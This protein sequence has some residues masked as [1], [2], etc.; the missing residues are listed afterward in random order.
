MK[1]Y[2]LIDS[3][4]GQKLEAFGEILLIRPCQAAVWKPQ[5]SREWERADALF[6]REGKGGWQMKRKLPSSW[7][8][9]I[10]GIILKAAPTDFGHL[11]IFPEHQ[12]IWRLMKERMRKEFSF[13]N[14]FAYSGAASLIAAKEGAKVCHVDASKPMVAWARENAELNRLDKAPIR[15]IIDDAVKF[16]K[17]EQ[18]RGVRYDGILLDPPS[19]GRGPKGEVFKIEEEVEALLQACFDVLSEKPS[20]MIFSSHTPGFTPTVLMNLLRQKREK[21]KI[22]SGELLIES[23]AGFSLPSGNY[24]IWSAHD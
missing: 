11:G 4:N 12:T 21:G 1:S 18:K 20:F 17:R 5:L 14:L 22:T 13:L 10:E 16:L 19:F 2:Q 9:E 7:Q 24:A 6:T 3:G 15:W 8:V 23:S